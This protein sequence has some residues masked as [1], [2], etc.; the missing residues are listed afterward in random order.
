MTRFAPH[1]SDP[2]WYRLL[3]AEGAQHLHAATAFEAPTEG[4]AVLG[5][6]TQRGIE[7]TLS[8][9][10]LPWLDPELQVVYG[11]EALLA[12]LKATASVLDASGRR[13]PRRGRSGLIG[14]R[15]RG[16]PAAASRE[17][18]RFLDQTVEPAAVV[19]LMSLLTHAGAASELPSKLPSSKAI[20]RRAVAKWQ[21]IDTDWIAAYV[22][23]LIEVVQPTRSRLRALVSALRPSDP[24]TVFLPSYRVLYTLACLLARTG[25]QG[26]A[27]NALLNALRMAPGLERR[28]R[29]AEWAWSDPGLEGLRDYSEIDFATLVGHL[30]P[31]RERPARGHGKG[32]DEHRDV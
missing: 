5:P 12:L 10:D 31:D 9:T 8:A 15:W 23:D 11:I 29:L 18:A 16:S 22:R 32:L 20:D 4:F 13:W 1:L 27:A 19:A 26:S 3:Y 30:P 17:L 7:E 24:P 25:E 2:T 6:E 21:T 28:K 14:A